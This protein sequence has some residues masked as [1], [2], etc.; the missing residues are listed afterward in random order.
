MNCAFADGSIKFMPFTMNRIN[1]NRLGHRADK[2]VVD[3]S[4]F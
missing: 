3:M 4:A 1:F 2:Q